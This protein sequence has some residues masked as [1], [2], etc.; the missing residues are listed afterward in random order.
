MVEE[1]VWVRLSICVTGSMHWDKDRI[2][3]LEVVHGHPIAQVSDSVWWP[4]CQKGG[5]SYLKSESQEHWQQCPRFQPSPAANAKTF[6]E[7]LPLGVPPPHRKKMF[8]CQKRFLRF[9]GHLTNL[10]TAWI[11]RHFRL[12][13]GYWSHHQINTALLAITTQHLV[14]WPSGNKYIFY[15]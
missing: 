12:V 10:T 14:F 6:I 11:V 2:T 15:K 4:G 1:G 8:E 13:R 5:Q 9:F 3:Q 7:I